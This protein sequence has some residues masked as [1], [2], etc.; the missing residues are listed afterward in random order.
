MTGRI[1]TGNL[2]LT[3]PDDLHTA[4]ATSEIGLGGRGGDEGETVIN[5]Y[6]VTFPARKTSV[7]CKTGWSHESLS[8][9][10]I[11]VYQT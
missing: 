2:S 10:G 11:R 1:H 6:P 4:D 5:P 9:E 3:F 7:P 8:E